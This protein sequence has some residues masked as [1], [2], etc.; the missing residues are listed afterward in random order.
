MLT[1]YGWRKL[2]SD[3]KP[4]EPPTFLAKSV[5]IVACWAFAYMQ[6]VSTIEAVSLVKV[7]L[8]WS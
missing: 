6:I 8:H 5:I 4:Y 2:A 1:E 3:T 7:F